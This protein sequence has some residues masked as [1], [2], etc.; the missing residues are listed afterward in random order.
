MK[1]SILHRGTVLGLLLGAAVLVVVL[2]ANVPVARGSQPPD[3]REWPSVGP[4]SGTGTI[5]L[6]F[7]TYLP[8]VMRSYPLR[9][10]VRALWVTRY[11]WISFGITPTVADVQ[12][13]VSD[14]VSAN[15]N[16]IFFQVRGA[17]DAY[18]TPGP[19]PWA[20][21]LTGTMGPSLGRDPGWD[22]LATM[23]S[24]AHASGISV[25]AYI[26]VYPA[27]QAPPAPLN[28]PTSTY[29]LLTPTLDITPPQ[30]LNQLTY[31]PT[32]HG[33]YHLGYTWR[34]YDSL[35]HYMPI[36]YTEY[37]W[38]SPAVTAVR[39][40][41]VSVTAYLLSHYALDGIHLDNVRYPGPEYSYDPF[42]MEAFSQ[43]VHISPTLTITDWRGDFQREQVTQL[44]ARIYT[45]TTHASTLLSAAVWPAYTDGRD[46]Y[47]QD[48][49]AWMLSGTIDA[50]APMMYSSA[51]ITDVVAWTAAAQDFQASAN[52]RWMLPGIGVRPTPTTCVSFDQIATRI[53]AA[54]AMGAAGQALFSYEGLRECVDGAGITFLDLL[55]SGPYA[56][57]A[58]LPPVT[59]KP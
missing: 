48:S 7:P 43:A 2:L 9:R 32:N 44:V 54:R 19:E 22:P 33:I 21:R 17:G 40:S 13:V 57:P 4:L 26:N 49:K 46:K 51:L 10:E 23:I 30:W 6:S 38:A 37:V 31:G 16:T 39:D 34:V 28:P 11:D 12:R 18:Y 1:T 47:F 8:L 20:S 15:F 29:G 14:A 42:T 25:H 55:R 36:T 45:Q 5:T 50:I 35:T 53:E 24:L 59:W 27:W 56:V 3:E 41:V 58:Q 52:G